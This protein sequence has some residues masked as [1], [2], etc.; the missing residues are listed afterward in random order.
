MTELIAH[1]ANGALHSIGHK[2]VREISTNLIDEGTNKVKQHNPSH[3]AAIDGCTG[4]SLG[5]IQQ[6]LRQLCDSKP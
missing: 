1:I 5:H 6:I 2:I 4:Y 3:I